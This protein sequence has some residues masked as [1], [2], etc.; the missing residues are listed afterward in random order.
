MNIIQKDQKFSFIN[1]SKDDL[2]MLCSMINSAGL[3]ERRYFEKLKQD[4]KLI[5]TNK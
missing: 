3:Q 2:Q 1:V 4:I 5:L